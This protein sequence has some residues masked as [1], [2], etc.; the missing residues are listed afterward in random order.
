MSVRESFGGQIG[1]SGIDA[2]G[3]TVVVLQQALS[4][5][6]ALRGPR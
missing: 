5:R 1:G 4:S 6:N 3:A 2:H